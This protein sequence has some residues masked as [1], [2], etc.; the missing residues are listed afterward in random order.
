M[1]SSLFNIDPTALLRETVQHIDVQTA[2]GPDISVDDPFKPAEGRNP[3]MLLLKPKVTFWIAGQPV[4]MAPWGEPP[5]TKWGTIQ[6]G[7][8][9]V[10]LLAAYG[11]YHFIAE[12]LD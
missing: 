3:L 4:T 7:L 11:A 9:A 2:Y 6:V 8:L 1:G 5:P 12:N 10:G